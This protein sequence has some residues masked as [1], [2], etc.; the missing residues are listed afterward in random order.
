MLVVPGPPEMGT[1]PGNSTRSPGFAAV[2]ADCEGA[3]AGA[4]P[5]GRIVE[6]RRSGWSVWTVYSMANV[7]SAV[8]VEEKPTL[9]TGTWGPRTVSGALAGPALPP[10]A[11]HAHTR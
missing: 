9:S 2:S 4:V 8:G 1:P 3:H 11:S 7:V 10:P 5:A 6:S